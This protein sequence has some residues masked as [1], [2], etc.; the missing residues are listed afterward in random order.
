MF[1]SRVTY[2]AVPMT[3]AAG[4]AYVRSTAEPAQAY[5]HIMTVKGSDRTGREQWR[6]INNGIGSVDVGRS[7][8]G[9]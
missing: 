4:Y 7:G 3:T 8:G 5:S 9:F 2:L 1:A 6:K